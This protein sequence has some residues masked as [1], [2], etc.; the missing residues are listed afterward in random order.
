MKL[1]IFCLLLLGILLSCQ[2]EDFASQISKLQSSMNGIE[3]ATEKMELINQFKSK[4]PDIAALKSQLTA[5]IEEVKGSIYNES[6]NRL[7][8]NL[9]ADY[10]QKCELFAQMMPEDA[11][12][13]KY[14][15][16]AGETARSSRQYAKALEIYDIIYSKYSNYEKAPQALFLKA[17]T[18]D[19]DLKQYDKARG[20]Y[21]NFLAKY[22][23]DDFA[24]DTQFLL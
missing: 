2:Q 16:Q 5:L 15:F 3:S 12:S 19:N 13:P 8:P 14:L 11:E 18:L 1:K 22:P 10:V 9:A 17:F 21:E 20:I 6:T 23:E 7:D 4:F 24:D